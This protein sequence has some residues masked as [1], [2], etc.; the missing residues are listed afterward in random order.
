ME[1]CLLDV[2]QTSTVPTSGIRVGMDEESHF[3]MS[4]EM[5]CEE[6]RDAGV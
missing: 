3:I 2:L 5:C 4:E 1:E 6:V